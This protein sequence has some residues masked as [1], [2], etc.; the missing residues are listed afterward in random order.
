[1]SSFVLLIIATAVYWVTCAAIGLFTRAQDVK[2][3]SD[4]FL[5]GRGLGYVVLSLAMLAT[6]FSAWFILGHQGL[7]YK[8]GFSYIA[9]FAHIPL[10]SIICV[11]FFSRLWAIARRNGFVTPA[12]M[13]G[14]YYGGETIRILTVIVACLYAIPY[15]ALQLRGA[16]FVFN[17]LSGGAIDPVIGGVVLGF[18][19]VLYVFLGGLKAAAITDTMQGILL[20]V[21]G[22]ILAIVALGV[23]ADNPSGLGVLEQWSAGIKSAG[24]SYIT[25]APL[26]EMWSWAYI[27]SFAFAS[28]WGIYSS[29][30]F[31]MWTFAAS[32]PKIFKFQAWFFMLMGM[33]LMYF[34][35]S[36]LIGV[37]GRSIVDNLVNTDALS[38][39]LIFNHMGPVAF[40]ITALGILAAMNSTAAAYLANTS[41]MLARDIYMRHINPEASPPKQ[42]LMGRLGIMLIVGLSALFSVYIIDYLSILGSLASSFGFMMF[43]LILGATYMPSITTKG[44][45]AGVIVGVIAILLTY[46]Y[47]N[48]PLGIH[49]GGWGFIFNMTTCLIVSKFTQKVPI[50]R[51]KAFHGLWDTS[52]RQINISEYGKENAANG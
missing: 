33:G 42:V 21:G 44:V 22:M 30:S 32:T 6:T 48:H 10:F 14:Y 17:V 15:V 43:P 13:F 24:E 5:A 40:V 28:A 3:S 8:V 26:G 41:T 27:I 35:F 49:T 19:V 11:V 47:W 31:T 9:Y 37:G 34:F 50:E 16:G 39:E 1:M 18:V 12:E 45:C 4:Y 23:L 51:V 29:P 25:V 20:W 46:F 52:I 36:P 38:L 7:V 2:K